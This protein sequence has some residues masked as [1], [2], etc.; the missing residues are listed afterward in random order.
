MEKEHKY[1]LGSKML[2][3][4]NPRDIDEITF[5]DK[6][7]WQVR[8]NGKRSIPF[9][10]MIIDGFTKGKNKP[11]DFFKAMY[12]YQQSAPFFEDYNYPFKD[13]N[14]FD[15]KEVWI[16]QLKGYMNY[17]ATEETAIKGDILPK[18]FY[19]I[20]YQ[21][22]M[23][24]ENVHHISDEARINVQK[25]HDLEMPSSYFYELRELINKL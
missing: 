14:I 6:P 22:H 23:I 25:I 9:V 10:K 18:N 19:H 21:Y 4:N 7:S 3:I 24:Q 5:V 15:Y 1:V 16:E 17:P 2:Q 12:I 13:F 8:E 11:N 20:L